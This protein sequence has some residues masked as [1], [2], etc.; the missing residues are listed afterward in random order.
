MNYNPILVT[1]LVAMTPVG[2]LRAALPL[3]LTH[4]KLSL[5]VAF[6]V[7]VVG[8]MIP[9]IV[10]VYLLDPL[11]RWLS[12][13]S[14]LFRRLFE[15]LFARTRRKHSRRFEALGSLALVTF[16]AIPL[17][18]TGAWSGVLAAFVF[19]VRPRAAIPLIGAGVIAAGV[20]VSL[21]TQGIIML[22]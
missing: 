19:G 5:P 9:V 10:L 17:P 8:N 18:M 2:E 4:Y 14:P 21:A 13:H 3:A 15:W 12:D 20:I 11:Q 1:L 7:S 16:V 22:G 6:S